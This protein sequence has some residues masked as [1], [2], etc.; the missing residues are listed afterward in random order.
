MR[1]QSGLPFTIK[2][3]KT[4]RLHITRYI[5]GQPLRSNSNLV[6]LTDGFPT[7][8]L[9]LKELIDSGD[10]K[11]IRFV[12]TLLGYTR[13][14]I[15]T[16][17][18]KN[19][20]APDYSSISAPFKGD[21]SFDIPDEFIKEFISK[22]N[23]GFSPKWDNSLHYVSNKSS[24]M[25]KAT[26]TGPFALFHMGHWNLTML[27][28][29]QSLIGEGSFKV[30]IGE[31][32]EIVFKDHR[33]FHIGTSTNGIGKISVVEDPELKM[34]PIAM[35]D[36]YSQ[37]VL[38]PIHDGILKKLRTLPCDRTFTQ[39]PFNNWGKTMG[40]KFWSLDLTSAT[41]RFPISLQERVI[42]HLLGDESKARAWRNILVDRD[43]KLPS[44]GWT[45]YSVGQ[46]MGAYSSWTTFTL[47]HHLVVHYAAR[48][49][50]IVDFDRYILLGDDI[51][52][53][54]DKVAR[55]YISIMNKLGVDISVAKTHVSKNTYE[56]AKRW[57]RKG[58]EISG[59]PLRGIVSNINVLPVVVK[60]LVLYLYSNTT[61]WRGSTTELILCVFKGVK[62]RKRF[63]SQSNLRSSVEDIVFVI[64]QSLD[65][66]TY[67]QIRLY[68]SRK[69][70]IWEILIPKRDLIH[71]FI[72]EI[73]CLGLVSSAEDASFD[74]T[75]FYD[76]F[77]SEFRRGDFDLMLLKRHPMV[78]AVYNKILDMKRTL[79]R[80]RNMD[81]MDLIDAMSLMRLDK[82]DKL[83]SNL[84][85]S[86]Q[87]ISHIDMLW[88]RGFKKLEFTTNMTL[89]IGEFDPANVALMD[90]DGE[91]YFEIT[92]L[93][94][95]E[96]YY[97]SNLSDLC[98]KLEILKTPVA[99]NEYF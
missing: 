34:R 4:V 82:P 83:M 24:P 37:L 98:D 36:Y 75:R 45:R 52:I 84:R 63:I 95:W 65:L 49:C 76:K 71:G 29:F 16:I 87:S 10:N 79:M 9:Y 68:L 32:L 19:Q 1:K 80:V 20:V 92:N 46:P 44:G 8:F 47:T 43:Y 50:G 61:L 97:I 31:F 66:N 56:F 89:M 91:D 54:H 94:P 70:R 51:V 60:Q 99:R 58:I 7:K 30:M 41:D 40:H 78:L 59:L 17:K 5:S 64:R 74:L 67:E 39:D 11:M 2:Y 15:P 81:E 22:Y 12:L 57:V 55:R 28:H 48:L 69:I 72:R 96:S 38:K 21:G 6:S 93:K 42:A 18:E 23:L 14:I 35:V 53:N 62:I 3:M 13:S 90:D 33:A 27:D 26:L 25:G 86:S 77:E 85:N 88:R 73:L